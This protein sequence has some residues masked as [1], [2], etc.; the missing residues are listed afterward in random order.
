ME[1]EKISRTNGMLRQHRKAV[2][3]P[4]GQ[5]PKD[6]AMTLR[7][8]NE[9]TCFPAQCKKVLHAPVLSLQRL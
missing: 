3:A 9:G 5:T 8:K 1:A 4:C 6:K 2:C 7:K